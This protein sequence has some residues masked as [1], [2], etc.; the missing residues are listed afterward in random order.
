MAG[1][2]ACAPA[3]AARDPRCCCFA[4]Q[5]C[6]PAPAS[7]RCRG[8][9]AD[10][11]PATP[12]AGFTP[13]ERASFKANLLDGGFV[14]CFRAQHPDAVAYTYWGYRCVCGGGGWGGG[15]GEGTGRAVPLEAC[16]RR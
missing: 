16:P 13:E 7:L 9:C 11:Q 12:P 6:T 15:G 8:A 3:A 10:P 2:A 1:T 14:D 4:H 5:G